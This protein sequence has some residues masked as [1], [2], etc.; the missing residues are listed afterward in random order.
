MRLI[1][2]IIVNNQPGDRS[3]IQLLQGD[4]TAIPVEHA[5]DILVVSAFPGDYRPVP[6]T[7]MAA[8]DDKHLNIGALAEHK[9]VDLTAQLG[10]WLSEP[11]STAQ[12]H[13]FNFRQILCFEPGHSVQS[14]QTIVGN[15]FRCINT[16]AFE[17]A[18]RVVAMPVV[19]SGNQRI[20]LEKM[21]P[22]LL[23]AAIF[24]L[25]SGLPLDTIKLVL[26]SDAQVDTAS[27]IF[28]NFRRSFEL[29][30]IGEVELETDRPIILPI[31]D[32]ME[33]LTA[34]PDAERSPVT[35]TLPESYEPVVPA[36]QPPSAG[37]VVIHEDN[38]ENSEPTVGGKSDQFD[39]FISYAHVHAGLI[40]PFVEKMKQYR[41][42]L[43][44]FYDKD[45]IPV[46][47]LW[48]RHLSDAIQRSKKVLVFLSPD[49]DNS[50]VCWDEFQCAKLMEYRR[51]EPVIQTIYL[52]NYS[53]EM[54]PIMGIYSYADCREGDMVKM[55][56][57][58]PN[59][60]G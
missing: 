47:G 36:S 53:G 45:S 56:A 50:P 57:I 23:D 46:G 44:I 21:L 3:T 1:S 49:Y 32:E 48:I 16:F 60:L 18:V 8:F 59:I 55:E 39:F 19:A 29:K 4:L 26:Y 51:K 15:I 33:S 58:I 22:S 43:N 6:K 14:D 54:P 42:D 9:M 10:C 5:T 11:L 40:H 31:E 27:P 28:E 35:G 34:Q 13:Q 52:Y 24:W 30:S 41:K 25:G 7:L 20:P 2:E 37:K 17:E 38:P 12:Q